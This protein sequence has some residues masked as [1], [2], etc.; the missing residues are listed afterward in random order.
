MITFVQ[1]HFVLLGILWGLINL[2][3][4]VIYAW[5]KAAARRHARRVPERV[6][7][8]A[9]VLFG[10]LGALIGMML[11]RHKT[12]HWYFMLLVPL[13]LLVQMSVIGYLICVCGVL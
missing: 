13:A 1:A 10:A 9:A 11:L 4:L 5:D 6:L 8:G 7:L 2:I 12:K 3:T